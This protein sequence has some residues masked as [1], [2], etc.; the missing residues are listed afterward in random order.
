MTIPPIKFEAG[1]TFGYSRANAEFGFMGVSEQQQREHYDSI[2]ADY[3]AHYSDASSCEYRW[4]F[5]YEPMFDG[6]DLAGMNVLDAMCGGGQTTEYLLAQGASV[7]GLDISDQVLETFQARWPTTRAVCRSL[8][9]SK[10]PQG[11][12]DCVAVVGG[13][14]HIHPNVPEALC[15][16]HRLL[17]PGG[18]LC[19]MEPHTGSFPDLIRR[20]WYKYDR[21]FSD[22]E[23]AIDL[24]AL[25]QAFSSRFSFNR[26][27]YQGNIAFLLVLNS[28]IFRI[29]ASWKPSYSQAAMTL[30]SLISKF[31][32]KISS[33]FV[34]AQWQKKADLRSD[35]VYDS[36]IIEVN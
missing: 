31:Q 1:S 5:I 14:H 25:E 16:I 22:N 23:A 30:E 28:L 2:A 9:D 29:P 4:R 10:L 15:E 34:I 26:L 18:Y 21:F 19:F 13:L 33:C 6:I 12:F 24:T 3:E 11:S 7:T 17:K 36:S 20:F 32:N 27:K 8:L 35:A